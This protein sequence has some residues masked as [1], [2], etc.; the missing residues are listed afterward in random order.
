MIPDM[1]TLNLSKVILFI[2]IFIFGFLMY[3]TSDIVGSPSKLYDLLEVASEKM[4]IARNQE[5]SY[6]TFRS[7]DG[8]IFAIDLFVAGFSTVWLDQVRA[9]PRSL[10]ATKPCPLTFRSFEGILAASHR[11]PSRD[12]RQSL[13]SR[14][15]CMVWHSFR[16]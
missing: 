16:V 3:S 13:P 4:P 12:K 11:F 1:E 5:G 6:L 7:V 10:E 9:I 15:D 8:L 2:S 14:R